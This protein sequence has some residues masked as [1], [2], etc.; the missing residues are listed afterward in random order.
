MGKIANSMQLAKTSW[1]VLREDKQLVVVPVVSAACSAVVMAAMGVGI[2]ATVKDTGQ[3]AN[4]A[5]TTVRT[6]ATGYGGYQPTPATYG[7]TLLGYLVLSIIVTYFTAALIAG[8]HEKLTG[9]QF[10]LGGA[11]GKANS[12]LPQLLGWAVINF[13]VG[14]I[15]RMVG[16]RGGIIGRILVSLLSF[17]WTV[18]S[19]LAVPYIVIDGAGPIDALKQSAG[20]LKRTWGENLTANIGLGIINLF[21]MLG[22]IALFAVFA[23]PG[24]WLVGIV[25]TLVYIAVAATILSALTGIYRTALFMYASTG[26]VPVGFDQ[27]LLE[28]AFRKKTGALRMI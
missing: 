6:T 17:A 18:V 12:R 7:V 23:V 13:T 28:G 2:W 22:A 24:L 11:F 5:N 10:T 26:T 1:A 16:E 20:S 27:Q 9:G 3:V 14:T 8:A 4:A 15:L 25:V 21:V 19:W